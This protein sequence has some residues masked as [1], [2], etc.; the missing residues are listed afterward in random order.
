MSEELSMYQNFGSR[1]FNRESMAQYLSKP[2]YQDML[3]VIE[4]NSK[5]TA[6]LADQVAHAM[7]IW[8]LDHD[9]THFT[10][11]FQPMRGVT[12]EKHESFLSVDDGLVIERF[13]GNQLIQSEP[14][15]SSF[16]SG[17]M[18]ST[19]EARGYTA[20]DPTSP[21]FLVIGDKRTTLVIPSVYF[22]Y[23]GEVLDLKRP[24]LRSLAVIE[25]SAHRMLK[26]FGNRT[27]RHVKVTTGAEQEFFLI[28]K[29]LYN[30]RL[31]LLLCGRTLVGA[32]SPKG[33]RLEDHYF[34]SIKPKVISFMEDVDTNLCE[35]GIVYRTRHNEVAPNQFEFAPLF[36]DAN[37]GVDQNLQLMEIMRHVGEEH[38]FAVLFHEKPFAGVNGSGKHLNW[39]LVDSD[40]KNLFKPGNGPKRNVQFLV[41][42]SAFLVGIRKFGG[43][44]I[45]SVADAGNDHRLGGMEAPPAILSV[46]IGGSIKNVLDSIAKGEGIEDLQKATH[47]LKVRRLPGVVADATDRNR[48]APVAFTGDKLEFRAVGSSQNISEPTTVLN[49]ITA[50][51]LE[52]MMGKINRLEKEYPKIHD[53]ALAAVKEA[54][55]ETRDVCFEGNNYGEAWYKEAKRRNLPFLSNTPE[56]LKIYLGREVLD[57]YEKN[58]ILTEYEIRARVEVKRETY[59]KANLL[60][61]R[62][63]ERLVKR[64][65]IPAIVDQ[66]NVYS[67]ALSLIETIKARAFLKKKVTFLENSLIEIEKGLSGLNDVLLEADGERSSEELA[68]IIASRGYK[69]FNELREAC[70][71]AEEEI[72]YKHW[73]LPKYVDMLHVI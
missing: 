64:S 15:A 47:T 34:G 3:E 1:V 11:W 40:G 21:A 9:A 67:K 16:P 44:L 18:R 38:G 53:A 72:D 62:V 27:A 23:T 31:D 55:K 48:T 50:Y 13:S 42:L 22:S 59:V 6:E 17:G 41:F 54:V 69:C 65:V 8:A 19:F 12:A 7:K 52:E 33:Q 66:I 4:G 68:E 30:N 43:L 29:K 20:W 24:L 14:D 49:L 61:L 45:S 37:L 73:G 71:A 5:L 46:Y 39:S 51:G 26:K 32:P 63:L 58:K 25:K 57:L 56:A 2:A 36:T 60:E 28:N 10:H 70:D 35:R